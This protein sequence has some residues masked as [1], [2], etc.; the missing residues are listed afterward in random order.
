MVLVFNFTHKDKHAV[1]S[2]VKKT[3]KLI[4]IQC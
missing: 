2:N 3:A 1:L 4:M